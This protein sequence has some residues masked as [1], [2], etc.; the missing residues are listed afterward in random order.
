MKESEIYSELKETVE[1]LGIRLSSVNM[2]NYSY[3][4][5]SGLCKVNGTYKIIIDKHLHLSEKIDVLVDALE[6][7]EI[8][9][10]H[11]SRDTARLFKRE[12]ASGQLEMPVAEKGPP[13]AGE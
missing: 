12:W 13:P 6:E 2:R 5:K 10:K 4:V 7:F 9:E 3:S 11:L 1:R 8:D